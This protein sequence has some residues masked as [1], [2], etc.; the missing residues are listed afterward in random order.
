MLHSHDSVSQRKREWY[1]FGFIKIHF[2]INADSY[3]IL[4][5]IVN[6]EKILD[7]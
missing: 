5:I 6:I 3:Y 4:K 2:K 1:N 7:F